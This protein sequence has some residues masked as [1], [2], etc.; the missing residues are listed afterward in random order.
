MLTN[1]LVDLWVYRKLLN[2]FLNNLVTTP[3][4]VYNEVQ[5]MYMKHVNYF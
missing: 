4:S 2:L 3:F 5:L 1:V